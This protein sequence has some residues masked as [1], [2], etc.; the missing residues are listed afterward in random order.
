MFEILIR[1]QSSRL[2]DQ[3]CLMPFT[4][5]P[6]IDSPEL[7]AEST[8]NLQAETVQSERRETFDDIHLARHNLAKIRLQVF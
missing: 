1:L 4:P 2:D 5:L 3:R 7:E 8:S 6:P